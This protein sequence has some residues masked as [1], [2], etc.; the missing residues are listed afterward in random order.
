MRNPENLRAQISRLQLALAAASQRVMT[1]LADFDS[2]RST[3]KTSDTKSPHSK[4]A[5]PSHIDLTPENVDL[6]ARA[7]HVL[8]AHVKD[9]GKYNA[10]K[11][12]AMSMLGI[13]ADRKA[14][15][16][17]EVMQERDISED[18]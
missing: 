17:R 3:R 8:D 12:I 6:L 16:V 18:E 15:T 10:M 7:Q 4:I 2:I 13:I 11:D 5:L 9:L 1:A 14:T